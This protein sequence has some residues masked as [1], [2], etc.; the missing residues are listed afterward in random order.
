MFDR[1]ADQLRRADAAE[2]SSPMTYVVQ[3][4]AFDRPTFWCGGSD[5]CVDKYSPLV[6]RFSSYDNAV[7]EAVM[8]L[9][10]N[11]YTIEAWGK[12]T[13]PQTPV[14][15]K[16]YADQALRALRSIATALEKSAEIQFRISRSPAVTY[17]PA[18]ADDPYPRTAAARVS[19]AHEILHRVENNDDRGGLV[20][21]CWLNASGD[22]QSQMNLYGAADVRS[23]SGVV[24]TAIKK[25]HEAERDYHG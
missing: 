8:F 2:K 25:L 18:P 19:V 7:A 13:V 5:F 23:F 16:D 3:R 22:V 4:M 1:E 6:S 9:G 11:D 15:W 12:P 21:M 14:N 10:K 20:L 17:V 24:N